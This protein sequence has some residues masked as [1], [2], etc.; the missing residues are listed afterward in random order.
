MAREAALSWQVSATGVTRETFDERM[1]AAKTGLASQIEQ[2]SE[3]YAQFDAAVK[4]VRSLV[5]DEAV[6]RNVAFGVTL[7]GHANP[8]HAPRAGYANSAVSVSVYQQ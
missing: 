7:S 4:A 6:G 2:G 1:E 8:D 3:G 5:N